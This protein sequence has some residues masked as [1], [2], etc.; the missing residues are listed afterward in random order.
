MMRTTG[1]TS[2]GGRERPAHLIRASIG[3]VGLMLSPLTPWNDSFINVPIAVAVGLALS[4]LCSFDVGYWIGYALS[5]LLGIFLL[6]I[7]SQEKLRG[8]TWR[9]IIFNLLIAVVVYSLLH[10]LFHL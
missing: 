4:S 6:L 9:S 5:N 1:R 2:R 3:L 8:I 10:L 7:A